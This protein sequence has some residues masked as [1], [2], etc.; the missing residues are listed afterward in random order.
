MK[1]IHR[2]ITKIERLKNI[3]FA[4]LIFYEGYV[5]SARERALSISLVHSC[6]SLSDPGNHLNRMGSIQKRIKKPTFKNL[7][8]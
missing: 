8:F 4:D 1:E 3:V 7:I 2:F 5:R 6:L